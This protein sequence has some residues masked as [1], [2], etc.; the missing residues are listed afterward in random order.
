M[1]MPGV[2]PEV[3]D[4]LPLAE[5]LVHGLELR[6]AHR[7]RAAA[8]RSIA[9]AADLEAGLVGEVDQQLR[10]PDRVLADPLDA[11]L[12]DQVVARGRRVERRHVRACR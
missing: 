1:R 11:D 4:D 7:D 5:L 6:R 12:L 3:A 10:L 9:R 8:A 2:G